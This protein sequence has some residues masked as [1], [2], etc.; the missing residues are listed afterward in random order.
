MQNLA[1]LQTA[2]MFDGEYLRNG[3]RYLK[4]DRYVIYRGF[5]R[6]G[7]KSPENFGQLTTKISMCNTTHPDRLVRKTI[8]RPL[9]DVHPQIL[10]A[11]END[12]LTSSHPSGD[13]QWRI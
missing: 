3:W 11:L 13:G 12:R 7:E 6:V 4:L 5:C 8:F 9:G 1:R 10:H 2:L